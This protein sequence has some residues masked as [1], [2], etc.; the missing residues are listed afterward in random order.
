MIRSQLEIGME[1]IEPT[2][3]ALRGRLLALSRSDDAPCRYV[4]AS[5]P[6]TCE[7]SSS[8]VMSEERYFLGRVA[9]G[10]NRLMK[11]TGSHQARRVGSG[12]QCRRYRDLR[13]YGVE[14][15]RS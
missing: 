9:W 5:G 3:Q 13:A 14:E 10:A 1:Q 11:A 6:N 8:K 12:R 7:M 2:R 15:G 4:F